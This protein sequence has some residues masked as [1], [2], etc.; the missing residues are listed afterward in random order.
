MSTVE[1]HRR[2][3]LREL[4]I[5]G[6]TMPVPTEMSVEL[7]DGLGLLTRHDQVR[8]DGHTLRLVNPPRIQDLDAD[9]R[10][11]ALLVMQRVL[12]GAEG[13]PR[14]IGDGAGQLA[15]LLGDKQRAARVHRAAMS[16]LTEDG[17]VRAADGRVTDTSGPLHR[18]GRSAAPTT[19]TALEPSTPTPVEP[20]PVAPKPAPV[21]KQATVEK[22]VA[23]VVEKAAAPVVKQ[24][25]TPVTPQPV[26]APTTTA[27][28]PSRA[29]ATL[30]RIADALERST[31]LQADTAGRVGMGSEVQYSA[32]AAR[33]ALAQ[34]VAVLIGAHGPITRSELTANRL[35]KAQRDTASAA[36][37]YA[38]GVGALRLSHRRYHL[39]DASRLGWTPG[40][41][42][43]AVAEQ[44]AAAQMRAKALADRQA[45]ADAAL[46]NRESEAAL[47]RVLAR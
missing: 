25:P 5:R 47:Q 23:V 38:V 24:P 20:A 44:R 10:A 32:D 39:V 34:H 4:L 33:L 18:Q 22:P 12:I 43:Q 45:R 3:I 13:K 21:V 28:I 16:A 15:E 41:F 35:S 40:G 1:E 8:E 17:L 26:A 9:D 27:L 30:E 19:V 2:G 46:V 42:E 31:V 29:E 6:G 36:L 11:T 37:A 14:G 7:V